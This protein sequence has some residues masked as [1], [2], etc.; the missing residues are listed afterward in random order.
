MNGTRCLL[1]VLQ[2]L[3]LSINPAE[4]KWA[5]FFVDVTYTAP[6]GV[7][8]FTYNL[9]ALLNATLY[10]D[11]SGGMT[12]EP[13][14]IFTVL[15]T[16]GCDG[17]EVQRLSKINSLAY[18]LSINNGFQVDSRY[19]LCYIDQA[20]SNNVE[21]ASELLVIAP[22]PPSFTAADWREGFS[23]AEVTFPVTNDGARVKLISCTTNC[24]TP[25]LTPEQCSA[26]TPQVV[27]SWSAPT[28]GATSVSFT[29]SLPLSTV[30]TYR[31]CWNSNGYWHEV[32]GVLSILAANPTTFSAGGLASIPRRD[33]VSLSIEGDFSTSDIT[34]VSL[35]KS[36]DCT[37]QITFETVTAIA[38]TS[39]TSRSISVRVLDS[40]ASVALCVTL[41]NPTSSAI[42]VTRVPLDGTAAML[43]ID[44]ANPISYVTN[45]A[46]PRGGQVLTY[47]FTGTGLTTADEVWFELA[48]GVCDKNNRI[49]AADIDVVGA[50]T[51]G[52]GNTV[53]LEARFVNN[54][55]SHDVTVCYGKAG[56]NVA[57]VE[58]VGTSGTVQPAVP[59]KYAT[60][61]LVPIARS[62]VD[63]TFSNLIDVTPLDL[64]AGD[65]VMFVQETEKC[66]TGAALADATQTVTA[67]TEVRVVFRSTGS[68][69]VCYKLASGTWSTVTTSAEPTSD[70]IFVYPELPVSFNTSVDTLVGSMTFRMHFSEPRTPIAGAPTL[71]AADLFK[72]VRWSTDTNTVCATTNDADIFASGQVVKLITGG[73]ETTMRLNEGTYAACYQVSGYDYVAMERDT[74]GYQ[75]T[76]GPQLVQL[77][78]LLPSTVYGRQTFLVE[79]AP[80]DDEDALFLYGT[81]PTS[82]WCTD[83]SSATCRCP[84]PVERPSVAAV[85]DACCN[86]RWRVDGR[87]QGSYV[88]CLNETMMMGIIP[89][90]SPIPQFATPSVNN[91]RQGQP[92]RL[93]FSN[94]TELST[95]SRV[96][97][98][99]GVCVCSAYAAS[100]CTIQGEY[101]AEVS[102]ADVVLTV[103]QGL[104]TGL[105]TVCFVN[106]G[107][108]NDQRHVAVLDAMNAEQLQMTINEADPTR[109]AFPIGGVLRAMER[110][111]ISIT[112]T[113]FSMADTLWIVTEGAACSD[114]T[115]H[116]TYHGWESDKIAIV[117]F[118]ASG[119][120][121]LCYKHE[122]E[123]FFTKIPDP[124]VVVVQP[125][126][127]AFIRTLPEASLNPSVGQT[128]DVFV[129][130]SD[131]TDSC[132]A[133]D[134]VMIVP[135]GVDCS[136]PNIMWTETP[137]LGTG[138]IL[139]PEGQ[140]FVGNDISITGDVATFVI[141]ELTATG[142]FTICYKAKNRGSVYFAQVG[143]VTVYPRNPASFVVNPPAPT[144][145]ELD[146]QFTFTGEGLKAEDQVLLAGGDVPC[147]AFDN[148][149]QQVTLQVSDTTTSK[150]HLEVPLTDPS[151]NPV[152][153]SFVSTEAS[154]KRVC[155]KRNGT[156]WSSAGEFTVGATNPSFFE[157]TPPRYGI[158][159][160]MCQGQQNCP[161]ATVSQYTTVRF[162]FSS[163]SQPLAA[164]DV[165][166]VIPYVTGVENQCLEA[167]QQAP[168][169]DIH[170]PVG[171]E[172][173]AMC[174]RD[175]TSRQP[176][177]FNKQG[178][179]DVCYKLAGRTFSWMG[180]VTVTTPY[181]EG[182]T[183]PDVG[184]GH[185]WSAGEDIV[186]VVM[187][188]GMA[189]DTSSDGLFVVD[190][191]Q[192]CILTPPPTNPLRRAGLPL[193]LIQQSSDSL[194]QSVEGSFD[195][196]LSRT[197]NSLGGD[198]VV[199]ESLVQG[200]LVVGPSS[201]LFFAT[202]PYLIAPG[203]NIATVLLT[204]PSVAGLE[205]S[206]ANDE[207]VIVNGPDCNN[208]NP[209]GTTMT[210][211]NNGGV[212]TSW[213]S[214]AAGTYTICYKRGDGAW[215]IVPRKIEPYMLVGFS[216][217]RSTGLVAEA[218]A[219]AGGLTQTHTNLTLGS[220]LDLTNPTITTTTHLPPSTDVT[221]TL[222]AYVD[223]VDVFTFVD[224]GGSMVFTSTDTGTLAFEM[225]GNTFDTTVTYP[226]GEWGFIQYIYSVADKTLTVRVN[227][228]D[229]SAP[230]S[231][232]AIAF[233]SQ[234]QVQLFE[235]F[236]G[237]ADDVRLYAARLS[238]LQL[239]AVLAIGSSGLGPAASGSQSLTVVTIPTQYNTEKEVRTNGPVV[240]QFAN[241]N[242]NAVLLTSGDK[243]TLTQAEC[244][245][246][247]AAD[248]DIVTP[249]ATGLTST[250]NL[251]V[252]P[253][254]GVWNLCYKPLLGEWA[255][256]LPVTVLP[257]S[258]ASVSVASEFFAGQQVP[259]TFNEVQ[260]SGGAPCPE[261]DAPLS[262]ADEV[263]L[264]TSSD[265]TSPVVQNVTIVMLRAPR[266]TSTSVFYICYKRTSPPTHPLTD[267]W[268]NV[269][270]SSI[271]V[272]AQEPTFT[273]SPA[274]VA[275]MVEG[276][277][278]TFAT[279]SGMFTGD[280]MQLLVAPTNDL[281]YEDPCMA[282]TPPAAQVG[283]VVMGSVFSLPGRAEGAYRVC[284]LRGTGGASVWGSLDT[285]AVVTAANPSTYTYTPN[286]AYEGQTLDIRFTFTAPLEG[287]IGIVPEGT[288]CDG[289]MSTDRAD[290][291][292]VYNAA[293]QGR[294]TVCWN[295]GVYRAFDVFT[296][297]PPNPRQWEV[298]PQFPDEGQDIS[299][300]F[301]G[302]N[303][304]GG[305]AKIT[306]GSCSGAGN[307]SVDLQVSST[308]AVATWR[309]ADIYE[310]T[311]KVC[312]KLAGSV[313]TQPPGPD[314]I[315][316]KNPWKWT[317]TSG[318]ARRY[319]GLVTLEFVGAGLQNTD[320]VYLA[321]STAPCSDINGL[322]VTG[323]MS[324]LV[325]ATLC[326]VLAD[327]SYKI[328]YKRGTA[329]IEVP[330]FFVVTAPPSITA[331]TTLAPRVSEII[332]IT[333]Q[334]INP[335]PVLTVESSDS[336]GTCVFTAGA[337][338]W[339]EVVSSDVT[340]ATIRL[341]FASEGSF[342]MLVDGAA[343][344]TGADLVVFNVA[345]VVPSVYSPTQVESGAEVRFTF[346]DAPTETA[347][348]MVS[349]SNRCDAPCI[350]PQC[351]GAELNSDG[352]FPSTSAI[353]V[354]LPAL[355]V[356]LCYRRS[357]GGWIPMPT[358]F[359]VIDSSIASVVSCPGS[360]VIS[361][362]QVLSFTIDGSNLMGGDELAL[363]SGTSCA[364]AN[365]FSVLISDPT[366][367]T[368]N[369]P[370]TGNTPS[371]DTQYYLCY[372]SDSMA[373]NLSAVLGASG[374]VLVVQATTTISMRPNPVRQGQLNTRVV[375]SKDVVEVAVFQGTDAKRCDETCAT[376]TSAALGVRTNSDLG[377]SLASNTL[378]LSST[379]V[380]LTATG[381]FVVCYQASNFGTLSYGGS[382]R[383]GDRDPSSYA[384]LPAV[385]HAGET[386]TITFSASTVSANNG[387]ALIE[388]TGQCSD[389]SG[390]LAFANKNNAATF[391]FVLP[392]SE[393]VKQYRVCYL[394][395][396]GWVEVTD[397]GLLVVKR[398][399]PFTVSITPLEL[400]H[401]RRVSLSVTGDD[402]GT[403]D[404]MVVIVA[405]SSCDTPTK[406][407]TDCT[408]T[409]TSGSPVLQNLPLA[410]GDYNLCYKLSQGVFF[411]V[412]TFTMGNP[413]ELVFTVSP[414]NPATY[415]VFPETLEGGQET[416]LTLTG[417]IRGNV[418]DVV[419][420]V[421]VDP[422]AVS[423]A[424][425]TGNVIASWTADEGLLG[426]RQLRFTKVIPQY[427]SY[428]VYGVVCY[429][430]E[431]VPWVSVP[432]YVTD[433]SDLV[434]IQAPVPSGA[435]L[436]PPPGRANVLNLELRLP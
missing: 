100:P 191:G 206:D 111:T 10:D 104:P 201:P 395:E 253:T 3:L 257:A 385:L 361:F 275:S 217:P 125:T 227:N 101:P 48:A 324:E 293:A 315:I 50:L 242:P 381:D 57:K 65:T 416:Q 156:R 240:F 118:L 66:A 279:P 122:A 374:R 75:I 153:D 264:S 82:Q 310:G 391:T 414:A 428:P 365:R 426:V 98:L 237:K 345:E 59:S 322:T 46:V 350:P 137:P 84:D 259:M 283:T 140:Y 396:R 195:L 282:I 422:E 251:A 144:A 260:C 409:S 138:S 130:C 63:V 11:G 19:K 15:S 436:F 228:E 334:S 92:F 335:N 67:A 1:V 284:Y 179:Y 189:Y 61:P 233:T 123:N 8:T 353:Q 383:V 211:Q 305:E 410:E 218:V 351:Y 94:S 58:A 204:P 32:P 339:Y 51:A 99:V 216:G 205:L 88:L 299:I 398:S 236:T 405:G 356:T 399:E 229:F 235:G 280:R 80:K 219:V 419:R 86:Q 363:V 314:L 164:S 34:A 62:G 348:L 269:A 285:L 160:N 6:G 176:V 256:L 127:P 210:L 354:A 29:A 382:F 266:V 174:E 329:Y 358:P 114:A 93:V 89:V 139:Q 316:G 26:D 326:P 149:V 413:S 113:T 154:L 133:N 234:I 167:T 168:A 213:G 323:V 175:C 69:R 16:N 184:A 183:T 222:W 119:R 325:T 199:I 214:K 182:F 415:S 263:M 24:N 110:T 434:L 243:T 277:E 387:A 421:E 96:T 197:V 79:L 346:M 143:E 417:N 158:P 318:D 44:A 276:Q 244:S 386:A 248:G 136:T 47:T 371:E 209:V 292:L 272:H 378:D 54:G 298:S 249:A 192:P 404:T 336:L 22:S 4:G 91:A 435:Y 370:L 278:I 200:G 171:R 352:A 7:G 307:V 207:M 255:A 290:T 393:T 87:Q 368:Q 300:T 30:G 340:T 97:L 126:F 193:S 366:A 74:G 221:L 337:L 360:G 377:A 103:A 13:D 330:P 289:V 18:K 331:P 85:P 357:G 72:I 215:S 407:C 120:F 5:Y 429:K 25:F 261:E 128:L 301:T 115:V 90:L 37:D 181:A 35:V 223:A 250:Y 64:Q 332:E 177:T 327:G 53:S 408:V 367:T 166:K 411:K 28:V 400:L 117:T 220:F 384:A 107:D 163:T 116:A 170:Y 241:N 432:P 347:Q 270:S 287:V 297:N 247:Q 108:V 303:L 39:A 36:A 338:G 173:P 202:Q 55:K 112:M 288:G 302:E 78:T 273:L 188:M 146:V 148:Q 14:V 196:C 238:E 134:Q 258:P 349:R 208:S 169:D 198:A 141:R 190:V 12:Q 157:I 187:R 71:S 321:P 317:M 359:E 418:N 308:F 309:G 21:L 23:S 312:Y 165:I 42:V 186:V 27:S 319:S 342:H 68:F 433:V 304:A 427:A 70:L 390:H 291:P 41:T 52:A 401:G 311:F 162:V 281:Y 135:S 313:Y 106:G 392:P 355:N 224:L 77:Q 2:L 124:V 406:A 430:Y 341:A 230:I 296:V 56:G 343:G 268:V 362:G 95:G 194:F 102:G 231:V 267:L 212:F 226:I 161:H 328:C 369:L 431:A 60:A 33:G 286:P 254:P 31:V 150:W 131:A 245:T 402:V 306:S 388:S 152:P 43:T 142:K 76:V 132:D 203:T 129:N 20:S 394:D 49:S 38:S 274:S 185:Q 121:D 333:V 265:C 294:Y 45:P 320:E 420:L 17:A 9:G 262:S 389:T 105:F 83:S 403:D 109:A 373:H 397:P 376:R 344:V 40:P 151:L 423:D 155:Y 180:R 295:N 271:T 372:T 380:P 178:N 159:P 232:P 172:V 412:V 73:A 424:A 379:N 225:G 145:R 252:A 364:N 81:G 425:C 375:F 246:V 239:D 147:Y